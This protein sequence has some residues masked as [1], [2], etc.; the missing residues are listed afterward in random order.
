MSMSLTLGLTSVLLAPQPQAPFTLTQ[1]G[2]TVPRGGCV[3]SSPP[4]RSSGP[5]W[6]VSLSCESPLLRQLEHLLNEA[7]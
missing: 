5:G 6:Q 1:A 7:I 3:L 4:V 2:M